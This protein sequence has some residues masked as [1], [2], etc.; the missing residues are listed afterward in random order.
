M[1][2]RI[3]VVDDHELAR[4]AITSILA[5]RADWRVCGEASNG[6]DAVARAKELTDCCAPCERTSICA[7]RRSSFFPPRDGFAGLEMIEAPSAGAIV[8]QSIYSLIAPE[9]R[10]RF[11]DFHERV[12]GGEKASLQFDII[13]QACAVCSSPIGAVLSGIRIMGSYTKRGMIGAY[14]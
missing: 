4:R 14:D 6:I 1:G 8:G 13:G 5:E 10:E 2:L 3:L 9:D 12:C 7:A 11:K